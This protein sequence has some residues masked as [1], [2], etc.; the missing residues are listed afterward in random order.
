VNWDRIEHNWNRFKVSAKQRWDKLSEQQLNAIAGRR[1]VL[2]ARVRDAYAIS[3]EDA[4]KQLSDWQASL[5]K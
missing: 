1:A 2:A 5:A 3:T 4:E